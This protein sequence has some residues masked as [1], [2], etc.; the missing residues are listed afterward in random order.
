LVS[1]AGIAPLV[2]ANDSAGPMARSVID[3]ALLLAAIDRTD[4]DYRAALALD[5]LAGKPVGVLNQAIL[6]RP[7]DRKPWRDAITAL[8]AA[9]AHTR[10]VALADDPAVPLR[11]DFGQYIGAGMRHDLVP[12]L[13]AR[14]AEI[15]SLEALLRD[16][17]ADLATRGPFGVDLLKALAAQSKHIDA[18]TYAEMSKSF[19]GAAARILDGAFERSGADVLLSLDNRHSLYYATAG[20]PTITVPL[21]L[22]T[23]QAS[24]GNS[25]EAPVG[26]PVGATLIGRPGQDAQLLAMA[27]A[28]EQASLSRARPTID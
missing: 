3:A 12:Y 9:G 13:Q 11:R 26:L 22:R 1:G 24:T 19:P 21:G 20:Y 27:Y 2:A 14:R 28:F 5:A 7:F 18:K 23:R 4:V 6:S 8:Q 25:G 17:E 15:D 10:P 16:F